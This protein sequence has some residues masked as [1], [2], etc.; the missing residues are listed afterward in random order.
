MLRH[1]VNCV[2]TVGVAALSVVAARQPSPSAEITFSK[3]VAP[4]VFEHCAGCHRPGGAAPFSL[5]TYPAARSRARMIG[6]VTRSR[7][8]PPWKSEPGYGEFVGHQHLSEPKIQILQRWAETGAPEGDP[9]AV[10]PTPTWTPGWQLGQPDFEVQWPEP[11]TVRADGPDYSRTFVIPLA[12]ATERYVRGFEF[13]PGNSAAI[14]HA[15]I[16]IDSTVG[17]RRLDEA[18][19]APGYQ[20]LL[21]TTAVYPDGHFLGWTPGQV[22]PLLPETLSWRLRP[23]TDLVVEIH[24][25]PTGR[26]EL[27]QP[28][29]GFYFGDRPPE[30][31]PAMLRL[32]RQNIDIPPGQV[33]YV[34]TD[35]FVLPVDVEVEAVQPHAHYLAREVRG[36]A[37]LPDG[38]AKPLIYIRDWDYRWQ[39]VYRF[40]APQ[41]F[42]K[43]TTLSMRYVF[44]N[45]AGNV[46]NPHQP[47]RQVYWGQQSTDEMGDLWIQMLPR[48]ARDLEILNDA[49]RPKQTAEDIVGYEMMIRGDPSKVS[50]RNDVAMMYAEVGRPDLAAQHFEAVVTLQPESAAARYNLGTALLSIGKPAEAIEQ[51]ARAVQIQ[52]SYTAVHNNW[53]RALLELSKPSEALAHFR[54]AARANPANAASRYNIGTMLR[55]QGDVPAAIAEFREAIRLDPSHAEALGSLAWLLA[56]APVALGN[57]R[58]AV[59]LAERSVALVNRKRALALDILA[60][61][62]ASNGHYELAVKICDEALALNPERMLA[63][64]IRQRREL[65]ASGRRYVMRQ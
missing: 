40:V 61:A 19:P 33:E 37:T 20:G 3:D 25:V 1:V 56:T 2:L 42:P 26:E 8:M 47:P 46:R 64:A 13:R 54:E 45:S 22:A 30:R 15:N 24:F 31:T 48:S 34:T 55:V 17:S 50:L 57:P 23:G 18:D 49:I 29:V 21:L 62:Q 44:D 60:A 36:T 39:H 28:T 7:L 10:P 38:T 65:Y 11:Y 58:E 16:R 53:G 5:L 59:E 6:I 41:M 43:G 27:V 52:P 35:S 32:G 63:S 51:Y 12:G 9:R 14:H 4:I